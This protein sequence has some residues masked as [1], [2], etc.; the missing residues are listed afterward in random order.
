M[1]H[2]DDRDRPLFMISVAAELAGMHPQTLRMYERRGLLRPQRT[3]KNT[4]RYSQRDVERLRRIQELT[5]LGLN[6]AGVER[7][8]AMEEQLLVMARELQVLQAQLRRFD[9]PPPAPVG[10]VRMPHGQIVH[11][12]RRRR[13]AVDRPAPAP[14]SRHTLRNRQASMDVNNFSERA[15]EAIETAQG[16]VRRGPGNVLGTEHLLIGVLALPGG[17]VEQILNVLGVDKG[18]LMTRADQLA[19]NQ[20]VGTSGPS[21]PA[22]MLYMT[23]R[24]K[25]ALDIAVQ[26]AQKLGDEA[27]GTEHLLL[28]IF[29][30]GEGP[31]SA[32]LR[33]VGVTEDALRRALSQVRAT[34]ED[35]EATASGESMLKK[36]TRDLTELAREGKLDPVI[37]RDEEIKR[38]IQVLSRRTK[39]NPVLIGEPGVGKTAIVEGLAQKIVVGDVPEI[40]RGKRVL[41]LDMGG[42]VA[43][44]KFRG[45]F[46]ERLKA[47]MDEIQR[48]PR[49]GPLHRR[50]AH[51]RRR[52][53][54]GGRDRRLQHDEA[55]ARPRRAAVR[56]RHDARRVPQAHREG[57][58]ARAPLPARPRRRADGR[59][60]D[61]DPRRPAR[62]VRGAPQGDDHRR[63]RSTPRPSS[64]TATSPTASCPT[65]PST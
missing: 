1:I 45:E 30:E 9:Q 14:R 42:M 17:V 20:P 23:P 26:E 41:A 59:R 25:A 49:R 5:E 48:S 65:R 3:A 11:L 52:G 4:R 51:G 33:D 60:D 46:E 38:V 43:G 44:S 37:G 39:N 54:R 13:R 28:G 22:E 57:R 40:L 21:G 34:G 53:R 61:R 6:L 19:Q 12:P 29:L 58:G 15:R 7:V 10:L 16:V 27:V 62:Q 18:V 56:R 64:R 35:Y 32:V 47:V 63:A 36:Y 50:A 24:A 31:G 55:R 8:L 2:D